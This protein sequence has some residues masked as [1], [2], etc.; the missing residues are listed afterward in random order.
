MI[1]LLA[2][3]LAFPVSTTTAGPPHSVAVELVYG[4]KTFKKVIR[5]N[6]DADRYGLGTFTRPPEPAQELKFDAVIWPAG[7]RALSVKYRI[8]LFVPRRNGQDPIQ[9][10]DSGTVEISSGSR[11]TVAECG[12][13]K[14][15]L[16]ID[17]GAA[18]TAWDA[19]ATSNYRL[20]ADASGHRWRQTCRHVGTPDDGINIT[21]GHFVNGRQDVFG[22][23]VDPLKRLPEG[24]N[25]RHLV[26]D[27]TP[28]RPP[29][30]AR[31]SAIL[32][33]GRKTSVDAKGYTV[34]LLLETSAG[35]DAAAPAA[36]AP[37]QAPKEPET[38]PLLR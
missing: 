33:P 20:T 30:N 8:G 26:T 38:V 29:L 25:V 5:L 16:T 32:A 13:W 34:G 31:G 12:D 14:V 10:N 15:A 3:L 28:L 22:M 36:S 35:M 1:P 11:V 24:F 17:G 9:M 6:E 2:A 19:P 37:R 18:A 7:G 21:V 23:I 27:D 4:R